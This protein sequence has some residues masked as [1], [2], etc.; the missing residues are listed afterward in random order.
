MKATLALCSLLVPIDKVG[1]VH[2]H[3]DVSDRNRRLRR[4]R[5]PERIGDITDFKLRQRESGQ[6]SIIHLNDERNTGPETTLTSR[7]WTPV[8][9]PDFVIEVTWQ[10]F[11]LTLAEE[12]C[13]STKDCS[14]GS[15]PKDTMAFPPVASDMK[16]TCR[17]LP[18]KNVGRQGI[19]SC[20]IVVLTG[21]N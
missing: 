17:E 9:N 19:L 21:E 6:S 8:S 7:L 10:L 4:R 18:M 3:L 16:L 20:V 1:V 2:Q 11:C 5:K 14:V 13:V 12:F 15:A